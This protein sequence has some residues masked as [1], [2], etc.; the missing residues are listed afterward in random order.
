MCGA[1]TA[2]VA[3]ERTSQVITRSSKGQYKVITS[4]LGSSRWWRETVRVWVRIRAMASVRARVEVRVRA[5][6]RV[7]VKARVRVGVGV[8]VRV[9]IRLRC[10]SCSCEVHGGLLQDSTPAIQLQATY[11]V[12]P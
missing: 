6:A 7:K 5:R 11:R 4:S 3:W 10:F 1:A 8:G 2:S 12:S 9:K